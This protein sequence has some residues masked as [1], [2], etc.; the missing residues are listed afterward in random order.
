M[1]STPAPSVTQTSSVPVL[2]PE[3]EKLGQQLVGI[4]ERITGA[5]GQIPPE[6]QFRSVTD[7][8]DQPIVGLRPEEE[9][10]RQQAVGGFTGQ[11]ERIDAARGRTT[12]SLLAP[13]TA[14]EQT[15]GQELQR[16]VGGDFLSVGSNPFLQEQ[17]STINRNLQQNIA[18]IASRAGVAGAGGG[19]R[20]AVLQGEAAAGTSGQ[21]GDLL[22]ANFAR[23]R[24]LQQQA[25]D[26][27]LQFEGQPTRNELTALGVEQQAGAPEALLRAGE[28]EGVPRQIE[29]AR[30]NI[31]VDE[32]LR[33]Q[34]ERLVP[35]QV[36]QS[37]LGQ[38]IG[39]S[40]PVITPQQ[41]GLSQASSLIGSIGKLAGG[42]TGGK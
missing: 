10:I 42:L 35:T 36:G 26:P 14:G 9:A 12:G 15:A 19:S 13:R 37:I 39:Q 17:I 20:E 23:E 11:Q 8:V 25:I 5:P 7:A 31:D 41:S 29:Q 16:T 21:I 30:A 24:G 3:T 40:I 27:L 22:A 34:A 38:R 4:G 2:T 32:A 33:Q 1:G 28:L 6:L 18:N